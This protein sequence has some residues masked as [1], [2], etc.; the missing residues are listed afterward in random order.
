M[1]FYAE[2][3]VWCDEPIGTRIR[4]DGLSLVKRFDDWLKFAEES[5]YEV[6][7]FAYW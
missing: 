7:P 2:D 3:D 6:K 5:G 1:P 4:N